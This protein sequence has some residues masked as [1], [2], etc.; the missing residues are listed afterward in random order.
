MTKVTK[1]KATPSNA[2]LLALEAELGRWRVG[3]QGREANLSAE[4]VVGTTAPPSLIAA[5]DGISIEFVTNLSP[6]GETNLR[7]GI[8]ILLTGWQLRDDTLL[9]PNAAPP[10]ATS[11][12]VNTSSLQEKKSVLFR[13][14]T[15]L[16]PAGKA[17]PVGEAWELARKLSK[18]VGVVSVTPLLAQVAPH[19]GTVP[20]TSLGMAADEG[21]PTNPQARR[22]WHLQVIGVP[23]A[24]RL[25]HSG[26][27]ANG[28]PIEPGEGVTVA[29][30]DTGYTDHPEVRERLTKQVNAPN[31]VLGL[32]LLD[33]DDPRDPLEGKPPLAFPAHGTSVSSVIVSP[34]GPQANTLNGAD[35]VDGI[36]PAAQVMPV[37]MT[38][39]VALVLPNKLIP[40]IRQAV[41]AGADVINVSLGLPYY[42]PALHAAVQYAADQGVVVIAAAGNYWPQ[43]VYPAALPECGVAAAACNWE[44]RPWQWSGAGIAVVRCR[45]RGGCAG[46]WRRRA[47]GLCA[48]QAAWPGN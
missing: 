23:E 18:L 25:L 20:S 19:K 16:P 46:S 31:Q 12:S 39:N 6:E 45:H 41:E 26:G 24:W 42:W 7:Q 10:S 14:V 38:T 8:S 13:G 48:A 37:R 35:Y 1:V 47:A 34:L 27:S 36:A 33:G 44:L 11:Q 21:G 43:V 40:A 4:G 2:G 17:P 28:Q 3:F 15:E 22:D 9:A 29:V 5:T 32:D 30:L